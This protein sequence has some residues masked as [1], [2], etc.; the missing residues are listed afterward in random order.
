MSSTFS[1]ESPG[2]LPSTLIL[3]HVMD[4]RS[5]SNNAV[6]SAQA[7]SIREPYSPWMVPVVGPHQRDSR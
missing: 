7:T 2:A 1:T 5:D 4:T 6:S 3:H